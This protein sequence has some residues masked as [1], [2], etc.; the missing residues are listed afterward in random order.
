[1]A[2][3]GLQ[4]KKQGGGMDMRRMQQMNDMNMMQ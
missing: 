3:E 1:M 4:W 2:K